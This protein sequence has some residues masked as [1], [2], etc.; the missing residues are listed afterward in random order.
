MTQP[1][2]PALPRAPHPG[3]PLEE[4]GVEIVICDGRGRPARRRILALASCLEFG[5][6]LG[7]QATGDS[8]P[9]CAGTAA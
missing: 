7:P 6:G 3:L 4:L 8:A 1:L 2:Y 5:R 9:F